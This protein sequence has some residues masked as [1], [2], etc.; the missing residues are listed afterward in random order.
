M[1]KRSMSTSNSLRLKSAIKT[2]QHSNGIPPP[3]KR[4][5]SEKGRGSTLKLKER[6]NKKREGRDKK[7]RGSRD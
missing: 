6:G 4:T 7:K 3:P 1:R 5:R 2:C